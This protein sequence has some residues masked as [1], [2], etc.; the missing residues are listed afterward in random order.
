[1]DLI[2]I[3]E[4]LLINVDMIEAIEVR[5]VKGQKI[6]NIVI[7]G[8]SYTPTVDSTILLQTLIRSGATKAVN[9]FF[10]V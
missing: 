5:K 9:Q 2:S 10:A 8:K 4:G 1:M 3:S 6:F 7:G